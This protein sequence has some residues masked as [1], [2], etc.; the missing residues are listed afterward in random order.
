M[1]SC[2]QHVPFVDLQSPLYLAYNGKM[3]YNQKLPQEVEQALDVYISRVKNIKWFQPAEDIKR[4]KVDTAVMAS[5]K[6]FGVEASIEYRHLKTPADWDAARDAAWGAAWGAARDAAWD[7]ARGAARDAARDAAWDA[8]RGAQDLLASFTSTYKGKT[9]FLTLV[10]IY[11]IGLLPI[12]VIDGK[13]VV[14]VPPSS[15][16]FPEDLK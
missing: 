6:A 10:D 14:Y 11:E 4:E 13:F 15:M 2:P 5:L 8:A 3:K 12:G 1:F 16:E 7:A 9:P